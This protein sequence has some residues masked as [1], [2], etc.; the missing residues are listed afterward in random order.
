MPFQ[1]NIFVRNQNF[2]RDRNSGPPDDVIQAERVDDE[3]NNVTTGLTQARTAAATA[4]DKA[5]TASAKA[6][7]EANA[8]RSAVRGGVEEAY[9][10]LKKLYDWVKGI[11]DS[12]RTDVDRSA[13]AG[14][15]ALFFNSTAPSGWLHCNGAA[16]SRTTHAALFAAIGTRFGAGD[17][18]TTFNLPDC[19]DEFFRGAGATA[20]G[21]KGEQSVQSHTHT[22]SAT[23]A[24]SHN[25]GGSAGANGAH[26]HTGTALSAGEH[27]HGGNYWYSANGGGGSGSTTRSGQNVTSTESAGAHTHALSINGAANHSHT[28]SADGSHTHAVTVSATGSAETRPRFIALLPCIKT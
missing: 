27:S 13:P 10:T 12:L 2:V 7:T 4:D 23:A 25:H 19:R 1:G 5:V 8:A 11:T 17:G 26:T 3:F 22:A 18:S 24:G 6:T 28:I 20:V 16:V 21:I 15:M 9:D 14:Q